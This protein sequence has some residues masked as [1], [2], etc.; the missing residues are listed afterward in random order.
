[1]QDERWRF[2]DLWAL[3]ILGD[4][5]GDGLSLNLCYLITSTRPDLLL[6]LDLEDPLLCLARHSVKEGATSHYHIK[7]LIEIL[8]NWPALDIVTPNISSIGNGTYILDVDNGC[9]VH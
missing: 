9:N 8:L 6:G 1:M 4:G 7:S 5:E 2:F 3:C